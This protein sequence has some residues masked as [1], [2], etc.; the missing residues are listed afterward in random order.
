[1]RES[2]TGKRPQQAWKN[3]VPIVGQRGW[4]GWGHVSHVVGK[5]MS[6][7]LLPHLVKERLQVGSVGLGVEQW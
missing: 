4:R 6:L 5:A 2:K 1:M 7:M 3:S